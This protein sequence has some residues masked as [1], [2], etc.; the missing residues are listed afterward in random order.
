MIPV[1]NC[2]EADVLVV[3]GG[4]GGLMAAISAARSGC[5]NVVLMEKMPSQRLRCHGQRPFQLLHPGLSRRGYQ[6][7]LP[8]D[9]AEPCRQLQGSQPDVQVPQEKFRAGTALG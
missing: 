5:K 1:K 2:I 3:G 8:G 7:G 9:H 6:A 4:I